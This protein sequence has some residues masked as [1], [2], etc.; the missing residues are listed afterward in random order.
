MRII[1]HNSFFTGEIGERIAEVEA[2]QRIT[3]EEEDHIQNLLLLQNLLNQSLLGAVDQ[4]QIYRHLV[5]CI[6]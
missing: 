5:Q 3:R 2:N 6:P 1:I 4:V